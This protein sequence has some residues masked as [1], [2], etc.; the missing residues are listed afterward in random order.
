MPKKKQAKEKIVE[1]NYDRVVWT[2]SWQDWLAARDYFFQKLSPATEGITMQLSPDYGP[3]MC[4]THIEDGE[5][6]TLAIV[7]AA[8]TEN[9]EAKAFWAPPKE[10]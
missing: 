1:V 5:K 10:G 7:S 8:F 2:K 6:K 9:T 3:F 4:F